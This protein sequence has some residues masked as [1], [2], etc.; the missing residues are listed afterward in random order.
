LY[1]AGIVSNQLVKMYPEPCPELVQKVLV[2][3]KQHSMI[4][5][6]IKAEKY[7]TAAQ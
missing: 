6:Q 7:S 3:D 5:A 4:I 2:L 1:E